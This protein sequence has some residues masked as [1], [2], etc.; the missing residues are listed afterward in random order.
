MTR[1]LLQCLLVGCVLCVGNCQA[2]SPSREKDDLRMGDNAILK[3]L[4]LRA[5]SP[6]ICSEQP[7]ACA[8]PDSIELGTA[9][10]AARN[11]P[12]SLRALARLHR[13]SLDGGYAETFDQ[14][15]CEKAKSVEKYLSALDPEDLRKQCVSEVETA[16][17]STPLLKQAK[18]NYVC[19]SVKDIRS[20]LDQSLQMVK[21]PPKSCEP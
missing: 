10:I 7:A 5:I 8:S 14:L 12:G 21:N 15:L 18:V 1:T 3:R 11:T 17:K 13:F 6:Y 19:A 16:Q 9:L 4:A 20:N 2:Q